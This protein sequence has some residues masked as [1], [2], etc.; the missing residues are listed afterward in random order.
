MKVKGICFSGLVL[1]LLGAGVA[2][3]GQDIRGSIVGNLTDSSGAA[4]PG[5]QI[6]VRN[7]G[8]GIEFKTTTG[9]TGT[10]TVPDLLAGVYEVGVGKEGFKTY[11]ASGIRL[12]SGQTARQD[13]MLE[14]GEVAQTVN[15]SAAPQLVQ[16]DSPT[17]GGS[18]LTRELTDL[19]F[20][21]TTTD[22]LFQLVPGMSQGI[23][24]GNANPTLAGPPTW[25]LATSR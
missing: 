5:A 7:E 20:V 21:T 18:L 6:T 2:L 25:A 13:I 23:T 19:P 12:L 1:F 24:N 16:T 22:A 8:T 17:I 10:Y 15:V 3:Y 4:V 14:L 9:A 11:R